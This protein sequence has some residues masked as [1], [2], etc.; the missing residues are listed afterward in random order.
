MLFW[1]CPWLSAKLAQRG[2]RFRYTSEYSR[3]GF[4]LMFSQ[5][6]DVVCTKYLSG[7]FSSIEMGLFKA[8]IVNMKLE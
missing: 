4:S 2:R 5:W 3:S 1:A 8:L 7:M 6:N